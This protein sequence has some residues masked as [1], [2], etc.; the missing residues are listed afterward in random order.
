M[1]NEKI[2]ITVCIHS[3]ESSSVS[4]HEPDP[5]TT[6]DDPDAFARREIRAGKRNRIEFRATQGILLF[7]LSA[8]ASVHLRE[9]V[10][11]AFDVAVMVSLALFTACVLVALCSERLAARLVPRR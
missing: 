4:T 11:A 6:T 10:S 8:A 1:V 3:V 5:P 9:T 2:D 7:G